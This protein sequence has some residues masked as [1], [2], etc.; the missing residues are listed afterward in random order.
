MESREEALVD[1]LSRPGAASSVWTLD[2]SQR[3]CRA[4]LRREAKTFY[5]ATRFL[6][7][8]KRDAIEA[9]YAVF[10]TADDVADEGTLPDPERHAL[11]EQISFAIER[12]RD[13]S[14]S[15]DAPWCA[16]LRRAFASF[17][18]ATS[19]AVRLIGTAR[20]DVDGIRCETLDDLI[21]YCAAI[22]G[23]VGRCSMPILGA[24]DADSL[25]RAERLGVA[26][27]LTNVLRDM[28]A[29]A[30]KGRTYLPMEYASSPDRGAAIL[31]SVARRYYKEAQILAHQL[32]NDGSRFALL[33]MA[34]LYEAVL[35]GRLGFWGKVRRTVV[36]F[37]R[38]NVGM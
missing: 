7:R 38:A 34:S 8:P 17:P 23:T 19:D 15:N 24:T 5:R 6:P 33:L 16:A 26:L 21:A 9:L 35:E 30:A 29:D 20:Q 3:W 2:A 32:P 13:S 1:I 37:V 11:L 12:V 14:V 36:C 10:R 18:I 22:A 27:Q 31:A 28:H 4:L 25:D